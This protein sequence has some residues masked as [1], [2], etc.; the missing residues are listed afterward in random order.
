MKG[1]RGFE[2]LRGYKVDEIMWWWVVAGSVARDALTLKRSE[3]KRA[4]VFLWVKVYREGSDGVEVCG[5][6]M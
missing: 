4:G 2:S 3:P 6:V 1:D 5:E